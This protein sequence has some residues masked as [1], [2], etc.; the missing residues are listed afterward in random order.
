MFTRCVY[1]I[2]ITVKLLLGIF[3]TYITADIRSSVMYLFQTFK[4]IICY[5]DVLKKYIYGIYLYFCFRM[6]L[7]FFTIFGIN[8]A[9]AY[10]SS[11]YS[12]NSSIY[13]LHLIF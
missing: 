3:I 2:V 9:L 7:N 6:N 12:S 10:K 1:C 5:H 8:L 11:F 4:K 13:H